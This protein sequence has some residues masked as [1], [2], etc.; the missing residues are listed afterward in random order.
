MWNKTARRSDP[1][2]KR[3]QHTASG[4]GEET[5]ARA[6]EALFR[7]G[8]SADRPVMSARIL[9]LQRSTDRTV[10]QVESPADPA[11]PANPAKPARRRAPE[12]RPRP[13]LRSG[14]FHA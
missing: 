14:A 13:V 2:R 7:W 3:P 4:E 12:R 1:A 11:R 5:F 6:V 10:E 8:Q 9:W